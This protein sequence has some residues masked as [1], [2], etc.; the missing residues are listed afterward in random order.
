[1]SNNPRASKGRIIS[2][3]VE[4][5]Y[6]PGC[7][8]FRKAQDALETVIAEERLP[9]PIHLT[10]SDISVPPLMILDGQPVNH[11]FKQNCLEELREHINRHWSALTT[12]AV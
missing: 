4:L 8:T 7:G 6:S 2:M 12:T 3:R 5:V 9:L 1:M 10:E 11:C